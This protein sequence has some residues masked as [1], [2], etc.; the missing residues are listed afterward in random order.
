MY[1]KW[2]RIVTVLSHSL[3]VGKRGRKV[4]GVWSC[5]EKAIVFVNK[6]FE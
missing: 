2:L 4:C 1:E 3:F 5:G 6:R